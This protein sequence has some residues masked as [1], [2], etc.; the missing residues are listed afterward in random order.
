MISSTVAENKPKEASARRSR[1]EPEKIHRIWRV[2]AAP[3]TAM[4]TT[5]S[6]PTWDIVVR[7]MATQYEIQ[8]IIWIT[9]VDLRCVLV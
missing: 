9:Q 7:S 4:E 8:H 2:P 5:L 3:R 1:F 6:L